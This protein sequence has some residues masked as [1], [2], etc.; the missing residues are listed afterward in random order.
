MLDATKINYSQKRLLG[1]QHTANTKAFYEEEDG[2]VL[3]QHAKE[4]WIDKVDVVPP[5][6]STDLIRV[7]KNLELV[8]DKTVKGR[9][10]FYAVDG[11]GKRIRGFIPPSYGINYN[12]SLEIAGKK[13]PSSH[14][15]NWIFDYANG[16][17]TFENTPPAGTLTISAYQY[18]GR[19]FAQYLDN[20]NNS[21]ARGVLG[22]DTPSL[23]YTI[24]HNMSSFD[25]DVTIYVFD[26]VEGK[27]YWK[28]DV[29]PLIIMDEN[30]VRLQLT[31]EHP[32]RFIIKSYATPEWI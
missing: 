1:K 7:Y 6:A 23:E 18:I 29:V 16:V 5:T 21:V 2:I 26:E 9:K 12:V 15:S 32:I 27:N 17:L 28:K 25:I 14:S 13:I 24:Q 20:E 31:E 30:R 22:V 4:I 8:E 3:Y 10:S 11:E 19:T